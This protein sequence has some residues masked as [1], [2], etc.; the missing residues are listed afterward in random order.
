MSE[1]NTDINKLITCRPGTIIPIP[2]TFR[3]MTKREYMAL[4]ILASMLGASDNDGHLNAVG[5]GLADEAVA[6]ADALIKAL[7]KKPKED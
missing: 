2:K 3:D 1:D 4:H 5:A 6:E 7:A